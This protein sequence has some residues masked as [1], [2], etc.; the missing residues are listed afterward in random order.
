MEACQGGDL[1]EKDVFGAY[2]L[3]VREDVPPTGGDLGD[4]VPMP[5]VAVSLGEVGGIPPTTGSLFEG[6]AGRPGLRGGMP[7][8][9][10]LGDDGI[11]REES[12]AQLY[13]GVSPVG[14]SA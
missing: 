8:T 14:A 2:E 1:G 4:E 6:A 13:S 3:G 11:L 5:G 7:P 12:S 10:I 9:S